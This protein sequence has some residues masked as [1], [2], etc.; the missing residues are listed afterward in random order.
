MYPPGRE[1]LL[2]VTGGISAYKSCDLLRRLRD[3]GYLVTVVPTRASLNFVGI[4]TWEALSGRQV[5]VDIWNNVHQVP[6]VSFAKS[7][8]AIVIAPATA[9]L[10][11][12]CAA[13]IADDL[14]TNV[15][16]ASRAPIVFVPAMHTE[17]W[18]NAATQESVRRLKERGFLV[19]EPDVG[20]LTSGDSGVGRYPESQKIIDS[21]NEALDH[22]ADLKG[23]KVLISTGGT[24]EA[25][26]PV[27][28]IGNHSSGKQGYALA[29]AAAV[30]GAE[31]TLVS[32]NASLSDIEGVKTIH[33]RSALEMQSALESEFDSCDILV[34]AA[35]IADVRPAKVSEV[36]ISKDDLSEIA[37]T[38]N[39]DIA[40]ELS[41]RK[42]NQVMIG[43]AAQTEATDSDGLKLAASKLQLKGLDFIYYNDVSGGQIFGSDDSKGVILGTDGS[44]QPFP[45]VSKM[46]LANKLLDLAKNK[47]G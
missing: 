31:V 36:K 45:V 15:V 43:F 23:R 29:Y 3:E 8:H 14:L 25:I 16:L 5:P 24:R 27:R 38:R 22:R 1:I 39:P 46:T 17:M 40:Q 7:A 47:L 2:G 28:Y 33:V 32:A 34:M 6:H 42:V 20:K 30:R 19:V 13:G 11:A 26:D 9:D 41:V 35:A 12:K 4:A 21:L 44:V 10:L 18:L 37:L